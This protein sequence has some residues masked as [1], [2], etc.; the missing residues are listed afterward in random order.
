MPELASREHLSQIIPVLYDLCFR[1]TNGYDMD[2]FM[3]SIDKIVVTNTPGLPGSL[4]VGRTAALLLSHWY[5]KPCQFVNHL[6]GHIVSWFLGRRDI[7]TSKSL[8]LSVS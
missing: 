2:V 3:N 4:I 6:H 7:D 5:R 8:I 1:I